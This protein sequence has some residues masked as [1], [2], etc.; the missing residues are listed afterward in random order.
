MP[1]D[2]HSPLW[3]DP[4]EN[5]FRDITVTPIRQHGPHCVSTT[6]A[7]L[8]GATPEDFQGKVNTQD[9]VSWSESLVPFGRK[10][11]YCSTDVR[12]MRFYL[13]ELIRLDDLF[14]LS[15]YTKL[16]PDVILGDPDESG[17]VCGSHII[18]MHRD[19]I[20]DPATGRAV[21]A[22]EHRCGAYHTKR[23]F[24]VVPADHARGL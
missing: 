9:P 21:P 1:Y 5:F 14:T 8:S 19:R 6:L 13:P 18:V 4:R 24:R 23:I 3:P 12:K 2:H 16:D 15:F 17:W 22:D 10:L 20:Y 7:M 11:A